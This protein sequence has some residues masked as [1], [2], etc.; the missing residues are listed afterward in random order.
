MDP[1][2]PRLETTGISKSY[3]NGGRQVDALRDVSI[4]VDP[5][6]FVGVVG[7]S[8]C[9]KSTLFNIIAGLDQPSEGTIRIAGSLVANRLGLVAYMPQKDLLLPW[10]SVVDNVALGLEVRGVAPAD[11]TRTALA[12]LSEFG[13]AEFALNY[14]AA[15]SGGMRQ[16]VAFLRTLLLDRPVLLL[17]EPFSSLDALTRAEMQEWLLGIWEQTRPSV[18]LVTHD[19]DEAL[20]LCDRV[21][22]LTSRPGT[23]ALEIDVS[24]PRPRHH[25]ACVTSPAFVRLKSRLLSALRRPEGS[26]VDQRAGRAAPAVEEALCE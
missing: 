4:R 8:G 15:L 24:I 9:G 2:A 18:L 13:L 10:R 19:V 23:I 12:R 14:P 11:R 7:P 26:G 3:P 22:V 6:E 1:A 20:L 5:A 25:D 21:Y 17:D 16:R